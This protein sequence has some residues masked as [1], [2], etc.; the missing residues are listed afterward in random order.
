MKIFYRSIVILVFIL[1]TTLTAKEAKLKPIILSGDDGGYAKGSMWK[2]SYLLGKTNVLIYADPDK[3]SDIKQFV[4]DLEKEKFKNNNFGLTFIV[5]TEA[6]MIPTFAIR[7]KIKKKAKE[8][9]TISYVLDNDKVLVKKWKLKDNNTNVLVLDSLNN[10]CYTHTG[11][12]KP[13]N[14]KKIMEIINKEVKK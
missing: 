12:V 3:F 5:N 8:S 14:F 13:N 1:L 9:K 2:S 10:V 4:T 11:V 6:T 7:S